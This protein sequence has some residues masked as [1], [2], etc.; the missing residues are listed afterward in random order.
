MPASNLVPRIEVVKEPGAEKVQR[1]VWLTGERR[2]A[3][4]AA[5]NPVRF[6][7]N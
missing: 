5:V 4:K 1:Y 7:A 2:S 3:L 6:S